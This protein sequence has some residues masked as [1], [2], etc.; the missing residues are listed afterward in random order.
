MSE[1]FVVFGF[2]AVGFTFMAFALHFSQYKKRGSS[3]C[4]SAF[5]DPG[6]GSGCGTCP[7]REAESVD[8]TR[9]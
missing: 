8:T 4:G 7:R 3:C 6:L 9:L 1:Y 2:F 5:D